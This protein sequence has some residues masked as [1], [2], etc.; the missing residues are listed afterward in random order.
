VT[1]SRKPIPS[2]VERLAVA[3]REAYIAAFVEYNPHPCSGPP[4]LWEDVSGLGRWGWR[5]I[6]LHLL[7]RGVNPP[8]E[9]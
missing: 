1:R 3:L 6:A 5:A 2:R 9:K 4:P 7:A 8:E